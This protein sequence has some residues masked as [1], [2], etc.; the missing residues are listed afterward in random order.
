MMRLSESASIDVS[1]VVPAINESANLP[2][3]LERIDRAMSGRTYE[4]LIVDDG[5][6]DGTPD[7][8]AQLSRRFPLQLHV[9]KEPENG[10]SGA[11]LYGLERTRGEYLVVMDADLQHPPEHL[12]ALLDPLTRGAAEF[13]IGSRYV[14]GGS[15]EG[16][17]GLLRRVNSWI[18]TLLARP[19]AGHTHDPMSGFFALS[20]ETYLRAANLNP[21]GY[22]IALELMCKCR[23]RQVCEVPIHFGLREAGESKLSM[24]QQ[25]RYLDHL[26]RLYDF[27][28]PIASPWIKFILAT[29][30]AWVIAFGLYAHLVAVNVSPV[31]APTLAFLPAIFVTAAFHLRSL[32]RQ[33]RPLWGRRDWSDFSLVMIG[34]WSIC[35][36]AARWLGTHVEHLTM[37]QFFIVTFGAVAVARYALRA[38]LLH[39][40]RGIRLAPSERPTQVK[41]R[42]LRDAA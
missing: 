41:S 42:P 39:N 2:S 28:F 14:A 21:I 40:L 31:L 17:W 15:T 37:V 25:V 3:L 24:T 1:I 10:L 18:A 27:C 9:R 20:R 4:V 34:E 32:R 26:S 29:T 13:V 35:T 16:E 7:V 12:P 5:S 23:V 8:C 33:G 6:R 19:F 11:V 38:G 30:C 22:K 36:L